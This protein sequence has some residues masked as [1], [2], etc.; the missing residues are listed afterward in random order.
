MFWKREAQNDRNSSS[1]SHSYSLAAGLLAKM[2]RSVP[3]AA[4]M[5]T[6]PSRR[7]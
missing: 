6:P 5:R 4:S 2:T 7:S 1:E 3:S